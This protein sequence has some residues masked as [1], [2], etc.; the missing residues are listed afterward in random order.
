MKNVLKLIVVFGFIGVCIFIISTPKT[1]AT[2]PIKETPAPEEVSIEKTTPIELSIES[3][4]VIAPIESVGVLNGAM[5]VPTLPE[6]VGW[7]DLG[8]HP[9]DVGSAVLAGHVNW[10]NSPNA[11]FTNLKNVKIR[12]ILT[13]TNS[14]GE[15]MYFSV[16]DIRS[17]SLY[18][19]T[20]EIFS[21]ND[22]LAHLN[23]ITC[24]GL[25]NSII[26][27][28]ELRLVIFSTRI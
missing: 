18:A 3:I 21:S 16:Q 20:T 28:H 2:A 1:I 9:G 7:Y 13:I 25:W 4:G 5:A 8:T 19:D 27:S 23:L 11:V 14:D 15:I 12:D 26:K 17:Y 10:K 6:N 22:G 24:G